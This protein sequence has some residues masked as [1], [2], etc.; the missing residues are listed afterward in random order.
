MS[1]VLQ[2][3]KSLPINDLPDGPLK[4]WIQSILGPEA[5]LFPL[6]IILYSQK[7]I[8]E[9][10]DRMMIQKSFKACKSPMAGHSVGNLQKYIYNVMWDVSSNHNYETSLDHDFNVNFKAVSEATLVNK[11]RQ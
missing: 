9:T 6:S 3:N 8:R 1:N 2:I 4:T 7:V 10:T 5:V 11:N